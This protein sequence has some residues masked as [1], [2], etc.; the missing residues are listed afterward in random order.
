MSLTTTVRF[1]S[2][3][4]GALAPDLFSSGGER[5]PDLSR[6]SASPTG[7]RT[8]ELLRKELATWAR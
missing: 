8:L 1:A 7:V 5:R 6:A 2:A 4:Y 3:G